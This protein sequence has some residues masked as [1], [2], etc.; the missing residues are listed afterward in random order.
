MIIYLVN[1]DGYRRYSVKLARGGV[2]D[3]A[4]DNTKTARLQIPSFLVLRIRFIG[5]GYLL[6]SGSLNSEGRTARCCGRQ[7]EDSK[8]ADPLL[9]SVADPAHRIR[10]FIGIR[11]IE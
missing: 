2:L 1:I 4:G 5:S 8:I 3:A 7:Y 10:I 11:F 6:G 9:P